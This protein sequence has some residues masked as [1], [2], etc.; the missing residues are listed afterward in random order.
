MNTTTAARRLLVTV[1]AHCAQVGRTQ[2]GRPTMIEL[3]YWS[4]ETQGLLLKNHL[5]HLLRMV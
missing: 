2:L 5:P 4:N 3:G 1:L